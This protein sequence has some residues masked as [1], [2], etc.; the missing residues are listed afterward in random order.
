MHTFKYINDSHL[1]IYMHVSK[2][3]Y[4]CLVNKLF[5]QMNNNNNN[6]SNIK[7]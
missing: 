1:Y 5:M 6:I 3:Q 2:A 4:L 7:T